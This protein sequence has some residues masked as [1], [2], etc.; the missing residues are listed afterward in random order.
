MVP[1]MSI[2]GSALEFDWPGCSKDLTINAPYTVHA[3]ARVSIHC[4]SK[5]IEVR[6][7]SLEVNQD[8]PESC[9]DPSSSMVDDGRHLVALHVEDGFHLQESGFATRHPAPAT[10]QRGPR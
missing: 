9:I 1:F 2:V 3:A 4:S 7:P 10:N 8:V 6:V 5:G